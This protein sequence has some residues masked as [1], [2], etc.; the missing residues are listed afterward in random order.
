MQSHC[1]ISLPLLR[2]THRHQTV[3]LALPNHNRVLS[4]I[5]CYC[6]ACG[7]GEEVAGE[8]LER[9]QMMGIVKSTI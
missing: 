4:S 7:V 3:S 5:D 6:R 8:L 2:L 1:I 9:M